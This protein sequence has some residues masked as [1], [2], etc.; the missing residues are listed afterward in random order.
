MISVE[1]AQTAILRAI[2]LAGDTEIVTLDQACGRYCAEELHARVDHPAFDNSEMD[3]YALELAAARKHG[4]I[5]PVVDASSCGDAPKALRP[6]SA[7]RIY[8]GAPLPDGA[9]TV[10]IQE[11]VQIQDQRVHLP[12]TTAA[13]Q[14]IRRRGEDYRAGDMLYLPGRRLN[15][16]DLALLGCAGV[17]RVQVYRRPRVL[18]AATGN[19]LVTPGRALAPGQIYESNRL[20][21][22]VQLRALGAEVVD[23]G[24]VPD[25]LQALRT[26]LARAREFDF[27]VTTGGAS[28]GDHDLVKQA[29]SEVGTLHLWKVR[30]KPGKPIAFGQ[31]DSRAHF[32][33]LPGNPVSTLVTYK[34]FIEPAIVMWHHGTPHQ[35]QLEATAV[36]EFHRQ[37]GRTEFLRAR[38]HVDAG[39][40]M[41]E[42]LRGQGSHMVGP[43]RHTNGFIRV[44]AESP[45]FEVGDAVNVLP[46]G[47]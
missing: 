33:A 15:A 1:E 19:E 43:L 37:P 4:F 25:D 27:I 28:A 5:L 42:V 34:L 7:M 38:L 41:A 45:G 47:F 20:A 3:G 40:L 46:L 12:E 30:V 36:N 31:I 10:V 29:F 14:H 22:A 13:D 6:G 35:W 8:T 23:A 24:I 17:D 11:D 44:E 21:L 32:Y 26:L 18:L 9:D 39:R 16:F 2:R